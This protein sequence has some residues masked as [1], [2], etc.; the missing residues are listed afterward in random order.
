MIS[1]NIILMLICA[2]GLC[3]NILFIKQIEMLSGGGTID[4]LI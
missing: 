4:T 1:V 3:D 2:F